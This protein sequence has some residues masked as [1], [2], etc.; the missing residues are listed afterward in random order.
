MSAATGDRICAD[1]LNRVT[2]H[3]WADTGTPGETDDDDVGFDGDA[4]RN[5]VVFPGYGGQIAPG[6]DSTIGEPDC[7]RCGQEI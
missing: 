3:T 2:A 5:S 7:E 6:E 1:R 4:A